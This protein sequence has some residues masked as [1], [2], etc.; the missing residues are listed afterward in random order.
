MSHIPWANPFVSKLAGIASQ[1]VREFGCQ[2]LVAYYFEP[3]A[4]AGHLAGSWTGVP[5]LVQ[6]AGS[7][8]DRLMRIPEPAATYKE[9]L[10][11][12]DR[13][14]TRPALYRW[15]EGM[16]VRGEALRTGAPFAVPSSLFNFSAAPLEIREPPR[17]FDPRLPARK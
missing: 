12:A 11:A 10:R 15:F 9:V 8:L 14:I 1:V 16:G 6:H 5:L 7:D 4:V 2:V 13:V 3:Y 17:V